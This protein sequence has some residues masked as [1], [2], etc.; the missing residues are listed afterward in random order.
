MGS[1][2]CIRDRVY[3]ASLLGAMA[4]GGG[5]T[6]RFPWFV[7]SLSSALVYLSGYSDGLDGSDGSDGSDVDGLEHSVRLSVRRT[8]IARTTRDHI[9]PFHDLECKHQHDDERRGVIVQEIS[10]LEI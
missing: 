6:T 10:R 8:R 9:P 3:I 1:E 4:G 7:A 5:G 2:M